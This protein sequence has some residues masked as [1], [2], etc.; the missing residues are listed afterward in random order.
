MSE[1]VN[2]IQYIRESINKSRKQSILIRD[3]YSWNQLCSSLDIVEDTEL[4]I[5]EYLKVKKVKTDGLKYLFVFGIMQILFVQ[6][7][8]IINMAESLGI[9]I[10]FDSDLKNIRE[11]RNNSVGH[12]TKRGKGLNSKYNFLFRAYLSHRNFSIM[13]VSPSESEHTK[14]YHYSVDKL[15]TS[16]KQSVNKLL[17]ELITMLD[18]EENTHKEQFKNEKLASIFPQTIHYHFQ[19]LTESS[20][21]SMGK[22]FGKLNFDLILKTLEN[23]ITELKRRDIL[24]AYIGVNMVLDELIYPTQKLEKYFMDEIDL[25]KEEVYIYKYFVERQ[26]DELIDMSKEIDKEY[27]VNV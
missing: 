12:P 7:D 24:K 21:A 15:I 16:Q 8:A 13:T 27:E 23:F 11:I 2:N 5:E 22:Q 4:A 10:Q 9:D 14:Y 19:K 26:F 6:Q 3:K 1:I 25:D 17:L 20:L 18:N